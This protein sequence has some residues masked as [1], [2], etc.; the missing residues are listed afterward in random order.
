LTLSNR[1]Q[2]VS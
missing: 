2:L 1:E